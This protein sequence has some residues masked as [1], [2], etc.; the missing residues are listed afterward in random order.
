MSTELHGSDLIRSWLDES[1]EAERD[2]RHYLDHL[3]EEVPDTPQQR[4]WWHLPRFRRAR[5]VPTPSEATEYQPR[6]IPATNGHTP[7]V[8]G[9]TQTMFSPVKAITAGALVFAIGG[10]FL[11]AQ[12]F[13]QPGGSVPGAATDA[14]AARTVEVTGQVRFSG[15]YESVETWVTNDPRLTGTGKWVPTEGHRMERAPDYF[16]SSRFLETDE[17]TWRQLPVPRVNIFGAEE[18]PY[19]DMVLIG[20]GG[21]DGL[22]FFAQATWLDPSCSSACE[23]FDVHGYI[24]DAP[25]PQPVESTSR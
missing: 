7:T 18:D 6:P 5:A 3:L 21:Y 9:R 4:R 13:D 17:G 12:P 14:E 2:P 23:G 11:I 19:F 15:I 22:V 25:A 10:A 24:A 20:E 8:I 1:Y 16:L